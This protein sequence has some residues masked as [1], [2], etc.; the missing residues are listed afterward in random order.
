MPYDAEP[1]ANTKREEIAFKLMG[2]LI[3][4][5]DNEVDSVL[6]LYARCARVVEDPNASREEAVIWHGQTPSH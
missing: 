3:G 6:K 1:E 5:D 2:Y 4:A